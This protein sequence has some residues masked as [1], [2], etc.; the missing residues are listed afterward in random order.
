MSDMYGRGSVNVYYPVNTKYVLC[1]DS[2]FNKYKAKV[3]EVTDMY[4]KLEK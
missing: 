4:I 2:D 3:I 1:S